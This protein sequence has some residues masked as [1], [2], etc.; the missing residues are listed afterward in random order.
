MNLKPADPLDLCPADRR[1]R[2]RKLADKA[3][4]G[5]HRSQIMLK[6]IDCTAWDRAEARRCQINACPLFQANVRYF[7]RKENDIE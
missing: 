1:H 2:F 6:C 7:K 3:M 5:N 4:A